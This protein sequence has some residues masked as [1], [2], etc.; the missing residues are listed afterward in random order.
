MSQRPCGNILVIDDEVALTKALA[1]LLRRDGYT[2][3]TADNANRAL[4]LLQQQSYDIILCDLHMPALDGRGFYALLLRHAPA[5]CP[6]V[7]FL[8]GDTLTDIEQVQ[9]AEKL[10]TFR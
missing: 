9:T 3:E 10:F 8:T 6:R 2:V 4:A 5:L 7:I 1:R